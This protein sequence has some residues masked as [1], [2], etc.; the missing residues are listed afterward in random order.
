ML[1]IINK[2]YERTV[3]DNMARKIFFWHKK[4]P[5]FVVSTLMTPGTI[6][7]KSAAKI[8]MKKKVCKV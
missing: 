6:V 2:S 5:T 4:L 8:L 7:Y 1:K 3:Q